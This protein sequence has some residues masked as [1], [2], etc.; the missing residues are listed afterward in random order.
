MAAQL[1]KVAAIQ[2]II[3]FGNFTGAKMETKKSSV[4]KSH[5]AYNKV[6]TG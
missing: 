6:I 5:E 4:L 1:S 2:S 3:G